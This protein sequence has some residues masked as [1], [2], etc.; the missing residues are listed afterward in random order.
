M[1]LAICCEP[2]L[3]AQIEEVD[4]D[5]QRAISERCEE[6]LRQELYARQAAE[7]ADIDDWDAAQDRERVSRSL[8][9]AV[10]VPYSDEVVADEEDRRLELEEL[11]DNARLNIAEM[12]RELWRHQMDLSL[13]HISEP[14]R[15][16]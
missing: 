5:R 15:P 12:E 13:I 11:E 6:E 10:R 7:N 3:A 4:E 9:K 1:P 14:T 8:M 16:Y 2:P